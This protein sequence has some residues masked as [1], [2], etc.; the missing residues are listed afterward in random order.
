MSAE[1]YAAD[2]RR[3]ADGLELEGTWS[4]GAWSPGDFVPE[5]V[6]D[7]LPD[8]AS[9]A[10][11][12]D[13]YAAREEWAEWETSYVLDVQATVSLTGSGLVVRDVTT[14]IGTGGPHVQVCWTAPDDGRGYVEMWGW[15]RDGYA[16]A[17]ISA[18]NHPLAHY[19][20]HV[21]EMLENGE[22]G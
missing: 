14:V 11:S 6:R 1:D 16:R 20:A 19:A 18:P 13:V 22:M 12:D 5:F 7:Y 17:D 10:D 8:G 15:F 4:P 21:V 9:T 2:V 3:I